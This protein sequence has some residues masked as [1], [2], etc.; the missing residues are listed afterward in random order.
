M[1]SNIG[2][3]VGHKIVVPEIKTNRLKTA[4]F[5]KRNTKIR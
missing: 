1:N 4:R 3:L 5:Y 2:I